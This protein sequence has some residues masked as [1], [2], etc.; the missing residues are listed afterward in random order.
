MQHLFT[1]NITRYKH[2]TTAISLTYGKTRTIWRRIPI[3]CYKLRKNV[4]NVHTHAFLADWYFMHFK[5]IHRKLIKLRTRRVLHYAH[6]ELSKAK[7][8]HMQAA[9]QTETSA[10][11]HFRKIMAQKSF[12]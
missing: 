11:L 7:Y 4:T 8:H 3:V 2:Q 1:T 12:R 6:R 5:N 9:C 10:A